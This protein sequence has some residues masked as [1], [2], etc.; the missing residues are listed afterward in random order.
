MEDNATPN[1]NNN[2]T[3]RRLE[4]ILSD[5]ETLT[6]TNAELKEQ[7]YKQQ[8]TE[9]FEFM[10]AIKQENRQLQRKLDRLAE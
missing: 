7:L 9:V 4:N 2:G 1:N 10:D 8:V 5:I 3:N 6:T